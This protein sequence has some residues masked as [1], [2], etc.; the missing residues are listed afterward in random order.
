MLDF[1][2]CVY[3]NDHKIFLQPVD[4]MNY[5]NWF[6]NVEPALHTW[7]NPHLVIMYT[8]F[9]TVLNWICSYF[10]EDFY[11]C[12]YER[13]WSVVFFSCFKNL[14]IYLYLMTLKLSCFLHML[15]LVG[16]EWWLLFTVMHKLLIAM[17]SL[18]VE[19][20]SRCMGFSHCSTCT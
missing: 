18:V 6:L 15:P 1:V 7:D 4:L 12:V 19:T 2:K 17:S 16:G 3:R 5:I 11:I 13:C 9:H 14:F 8:S 10:V 20:G